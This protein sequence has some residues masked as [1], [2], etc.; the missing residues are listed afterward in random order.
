MFDYDLMQGWKKNRLIHELI[1]E[2]IYDH[3]FYQDDSGTSRQ[4]WR[5]GAIEAIKAL[6][7][8]GVLT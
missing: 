4:G 3:R 8:A 5:M 7:W 2:L 6:E 1:C